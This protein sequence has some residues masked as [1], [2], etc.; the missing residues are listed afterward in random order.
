[1]SK[2]DYE[3]VFC[4]DVCSKVDILLNKYAYD[5]CE[6][7]Y[8]D[9]KVIKNNSKPKSQSISIEIFM[10]L[11]LNKIILEYRSY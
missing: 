10:H 11:I 8:N 2:C 5:T 9:F 3:A 4:D 1:M 6:T 7:D